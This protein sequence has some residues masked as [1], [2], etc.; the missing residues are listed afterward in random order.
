MVVA[1]GGRK[2]TADSA[3]PFPDTEIALDA[4]RPNVPAPRLDRARR[5][6]RRTL[7][8]G[9]RPSNPVT[10]RAWNVL[11][12][13]TLLLSAL[14]VMG[15]V[16]TAVLV[17]SG[18]PILYRGERLG[19]H[20]RTFFIYK[21]RSL[22]ADAERRL[23]GS[24]LPAES[25]LVTRVGK[26][27]RATRLDELPQLYN[28]LRGDMNVFG[29][30]P[31]RAAVVAQQGQG[32]AGY[33]RRFAVRPGLLGHTQVFMP[34]GTS[35]RIRARYNN[36]LIARAT[37]SLRELAFVITAALYCFAHCV[38]IVAMVATSRVRSG[39]EG[40]KAAKLVQSL[41]IDLGHGQVVEA[42]VRSI[43]AV[44]ML[45]SCSAP[46]PQGDLAATLAVRKARRGRA[47]VRV[48]ISAAVPVDGA[49]S[50]DLFRARYATESDF[51]HY[52]LER[53]VLRL[54]FGL[55]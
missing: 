37:N 2:V 18:R 46:L 51:G 21:F 50:G 23:G 33:E 10:H 17:T 40:D 45:L 52:L 24:V 47:R 31:V 44:G 38:Q 13:L 5:S 11:L 15:V 54:T 26:F 25:E 29:P 8:F 6:G 39:T 36:I 49:P 28:I 3:G 19:L 27:L 55:G 35:K 53:H 12:A 43:T 9:Y 30:R 32:I 22:V 34:H 20:R 7:A 48:R 4:D 14:P 16:A 42:Q 1:P 41:E